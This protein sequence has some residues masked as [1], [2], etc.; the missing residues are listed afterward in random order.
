MFEKRVKLNS[1]FVNIDYIIKWLRKIWPT[2]FKMFNCFSQLKTNMIKKPNS[3]F[4]ND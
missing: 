2:T 1:T 4:T 3:F